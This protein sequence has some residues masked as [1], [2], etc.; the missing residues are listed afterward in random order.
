MS[1]KTIHVDDVLSHIAIE[2]CIQNALSCMKGQRRIEVIAWIGRKIHAVS[3]KDFNE[4]FHDGQPK[5][6]IDTKWKLR[7]NALI[8][9]EELD[10]KVPIRLKRIRV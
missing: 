8:K 1:F 3:F 2:Y 5:W 4:D 6:S 9:P 10:V 7:Q